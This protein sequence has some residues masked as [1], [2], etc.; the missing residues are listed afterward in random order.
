MSNVFINKSYAP[1]TKGVHGSACEYTFTVPVDSEGT[2]LS[3]AMDDDY[4]TARAAVAEVV[5][6]PETHLAEKTA[7]LNYLFTEVVPQFNCSDRDIVKVYYF[8]WSNYLS[9]YT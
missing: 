9:Y 4:D 7:H 3:W 5:K 1:D 6:Q 2:T 8:L